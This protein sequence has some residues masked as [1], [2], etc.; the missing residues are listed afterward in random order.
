LK[1]T[2]KK[3]VFL[4]FVFILHLIMEGKDIVNA[5]LN[6][7][8]ENHGYKPHI[9]KTVN[10]S[11]GCIN[12]AIGLKCI[13]GFYFLKWNKKTTY[14]FMFEAEMKGLQEL[15]KTGVISV[16]LPI[17]TAEVD[18]F[19]FLAMNFIES[20]QKQ[21]LFWTE[22]GNRLA[23]LHKYTQASFGLDHDNYI[24][25]LPQSNNRHE[26][27]VSFFIEER[28]EK[29]V[30]K[31]C[32]K[33]LLASKHLKA[34]ENLYIKLPELFEEDPPALLHGDLWS[35]NYMADAQGLPCLIDPAIYFGHR[36]MDIGMSLLFGGFA[37]EF[38]NVYNEAWPM[39]KGWRQRIEIWNLYPLLV[40]LI[41]F[42]AGYRK[43]IENVI[44]KF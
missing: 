25:S 39:E 37:E 17:F 1:K 12:S 9:E 14:P 4:H 18:N 35:G 30:K 19:S 38:Y 24:G 7:F 10:V 5:F 27:W 3:D 21:A 31:A 13:E 22:F 8:Y 28:L 26:T 6:C 2:K 29:L 43:S 42:G 23:A 20:G 33:D 34:F 36:E 32:D 15:H 44:L 41:L 40:H 11:G 16:P